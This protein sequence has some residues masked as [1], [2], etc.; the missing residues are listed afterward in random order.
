MPAAGSQG[1]DGG[2]Q[3]HPWDH[4]TQAVGASGRELPGKGMG[5]NRRPQ[6]CSGH[7]TGSQHPIPSYGQG[8]PWEPRGSVPWDGN[9]IDGL[10]HRIL[11]LGCPKE[12][13]WGRAQGAGTH[14]GLHPPC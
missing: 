7:C 14:M 5:L 9:C 12:P 8:K 11:P 1:R 2:G 4:S 10:L 6:G 3:G 13:S